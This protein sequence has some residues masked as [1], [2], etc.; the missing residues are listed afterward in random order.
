MNFMLMALGSY[1]SAVDVYKVARG[2]GFPPSTATKMVAIARRESSFNPSAFNGNSATGD[3]SYGLWQINMIGNLGP[4]RRR[5]AG[6]SSDDQLFIP[7]NNARAAMYLW[8]G[9]D[10]NLGR[11]WYIDGRNDGK[12]NINYRQLYLSFLPEAIQAATQVEGYNPLA[13]D[14]DLMG[15]PASSLR[16]LLPSTVA[17]APT[18]QLIA[19]GS[20]EIVY[21]DQTFAPSSSSTSTSALDDWLPIAVVG[22]LIVLALIRR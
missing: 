5:A 16:P 21:D 11:H 3:K 4:D 20:P 1:L 6:I 15:Q 12:W 8:G 10:A 17:P 18:P 13:N 9:N 19:P 7:A 14:A 2:A 22:G